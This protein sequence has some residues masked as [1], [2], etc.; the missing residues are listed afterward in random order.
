[1]VSH[2][3]ER[4]DWQVEAVYLGNPMRHDE[5]YLLINLGFAGKQRLMRFFNRSNNPDLILVIQ[6]PGAIRVSTASVRTSRARNSPNQ[7]KIF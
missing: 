7:K 5:M 4:H 1:V 6:S 3:F 2:E